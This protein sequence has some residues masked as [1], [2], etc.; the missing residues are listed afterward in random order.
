M[1]DALI[2]TATVEDAPAITEILNREIRTGLAIWRYD[3]RSVDDIVTLIATRLAA[4]HGA[5]VAEIN[6]AVIGWASY[7][8]FRAGEGYG[9]TMEHSV[10]VDIAHRRSGVGRSLMKHL[11]DHADEAGVHA[12]IG[13]IESTNAASIALHAEFGFVEVGRL[14]EVGRKFDRWLSLVLM[15]R[16]AN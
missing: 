1:T 14:P 5:F 2:R 15:Q 7:G 13:A 6:A 11:L 10:H 16:T 8:L 3:E 9:R 4:G 12:M